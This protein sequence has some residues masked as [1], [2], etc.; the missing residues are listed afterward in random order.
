MITSKGKQRLKRHNEK[1]AFKR[2]TWVS[3]SHSV[4]LERGKKYLVK[5]GYKLGTANDGYFT[6]QVKFDDGET[7]ILYT[8]VDAYKALFKANIVAWELQGYN[9]DY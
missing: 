3:S 1:S 2:S 6:D 8:S 4:N 7:I 5:A 9:Y